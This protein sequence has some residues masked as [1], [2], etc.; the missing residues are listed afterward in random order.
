MHFVW[1]VSISGLID[2]GSVSTH[3]ALVSQCQHL[4]IIPLTLHLQAL[5]Q[6]SFICSNIEQMRR[7]PFVSRFI[8]L[9]LS[10]GSGAFLGRGF[11]VTRTSPSCALP[12]LLPPRLGR[13]VQSTELHRLGRRTQSHWLGRRVQQLHR[14][15]RRVQLHRLG[16]RST[17]SSAW[18]PISSIGLDAEY[19][20]IGLGSE[21]SFIGS[22]AEYSFVGSGGE[23]SFIGL[24]AEHSSIGLDAEI[25]LLA[26]SMALD[27]DVLRDLR[28]LGKPPIFD[29]SDGS[30]QDFRFS[31]RAYMSLTSVQAID[32]LGVAEAATRGSGP[33][34]LARLELGA[35]S[36]YDFQTC[37]R[38]VCYALT[39]ICRSAARA[40][41]RTIDEGN[42]AE[43]L[44]QLH[45]RYAPSTES[46]T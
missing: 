4:P 1:Q 46:R 9:H 22:D 10:H 29:G 11:V 6:G 21:Y 25:F 5:S 34:D 3:S 28:S 36:G 35:G 20:F 31:F 37:N 2:R 39:M 30:Y 24:D 23:H 7:A 44:R 33:Q 18:A 14:L 15:G 16:R 13:R 41:I 32:L 8:S 38:Q 12:A 17:A 45:D 40:L 19:S 27:H 42:G 26:E 43:A